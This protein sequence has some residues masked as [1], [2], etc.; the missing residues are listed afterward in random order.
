MNE[1]E[2]RIAT[3][4]AR[5]TFLEEAQELIVEME[6]ALLRLESDPDNIDLINSV[7]RAAH[8][9]KGSGG[10]FGLADLVRFTHRV[11]TILDHLRNGQ[12][13]LDFLTVTQLLKCVDQIVALLGHARDTPGQDIPEDVR[14]QGEH[15]AAELEA[16]QAGGPPPMA[17][18][19]RLVP[20]ETESDDSH[21]PMVWHISLRFVPE[22]FRSGINP[23]ATLR[24]LA[25][26][27][28]IE[29][30][31]TIDTTLPPLSRIDPEQCYVGF[32]IRIATRASQEMLE[33]AFEFIRDECVIH[34]IP[35]GKS[36]RDYLKLIEDLPADAEKIGEILVACGALTQKQLHEAL[37]AQ[38]L[39]VAE[40]QTHI[41][42]GEILQKDA[43]I[44]P[45]LIDAAVQK[46]EIERTRRAENA[47]FFRVRSEKVDALIDMVGELVVL[48]AAAQ[49]N[50]NARD[51]SALGENLDH[52][53][54]IVD[55]LRGSAMSLR[56]VAIGETF[57]R[58]RRVVRDTAKN[59][60]KQV[61]LEIAGGEAE[62]DKVVVEKIADPLMHLVRNAMDHGIE[63]PEDRLAAGKPAEGVLRLGAHHASGS[64]VIEVSDD[65]RGMDPDRILA[66]AVERGLVKE[67]AALSPD[68][69]LNLIFEPGFSTAEKVS[70]IS[71]R[72]VGM[73]V[74]RRNI[75]ALRGMVAIRS[76]PGFGSCI[77]ITLPLT[78]AI[79]DGF[80]VRCGSNHFV[81][82]MDHV[83]ECIDMGTE[84]ITGTSGVIMHRGSPLSVLDVS[85][86]LGLPPGR[87][88]RR[89]VVVVKGKGTAVGLQVERLLGEQQTVIKPLGP[90]FAGLDF[91][92]GSSV[93]GSGDIALILDIPAMLDET[94]SK[95]RMTA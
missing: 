73:D 70:D 90:L 92:A 49:S 20:I 2:I 68:Q 45:H 27:G 93:L 59:L 75:E 9:I 4:K 39:A 69:I 12:R 3:E 89:S 31:E 29:F 21:D 54:A 57:D 37:A 36:L 88:A 40:S 94:H 81:L 65:G 35:P 85:G 95:R 74:V 78:M 80:L 62:L 64:I 91:V 34:L 14:A 6:A 83:E 33:E 1:D 82:P 19:S 84:T 43:G 10:M 22:T 86:M 58:F 47:A 42:I 11:E 13:R 16:A 67:G 41:P 66:K 26:L 63:N 8:T 18:A 50:A 44:N 28:D 5:L 71:G 25:T 7:F 61:R 53:R 32:E 15:L 48:S 17:E 30:V 51:T 79:I 46:Q 56:M 72:G 52:L 24:Y 87:D 76:T 38:H 23:L 60:G 55:S 77:S